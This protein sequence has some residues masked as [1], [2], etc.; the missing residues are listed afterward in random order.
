MEPPM[1]LEINGR[2]ALVT[3]ASRGLGR[4]IACTLATEGAEVLAGARTA[5]LLRALVDQSAGLRG[6]IAIRNCDLADAGAIAALSDVLEHTEILVLNTGGPPP[7]PVAD[8]SD[9]VWIQQ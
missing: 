9:A 2:R 7:G 1:N 6:S 5:D 4:A 3:A 8:V